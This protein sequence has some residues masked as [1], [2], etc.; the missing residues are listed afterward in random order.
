MRYTRNAIYSYIEGKV[1]T[2]SRPVY[3]TSLYEPVMPIFPACYI[4]ETDHHRVRQNVDLNNTVDS[5]EL[6]WEVQVFVNSENGALSDCYG[7]M[8]DAEIAFEELGFIESYCEQVSNIDTSIY[9]VVAR[10]SRIVGDEDEMPEN[11]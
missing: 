9:R 8:E 11:E 3:C 6:N 5:M 1:N 4:I 7:I 2:I 10:F